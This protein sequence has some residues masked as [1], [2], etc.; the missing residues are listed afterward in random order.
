MFKK[1]DA[2][3]PF[4]DEPNREVGVREYARFH[5][6]SPA[7]ASKRLHTLGREGF[8]T[9]KKGRNCMLYKANDSDKYKDY[10]RAQTIQRLRASGLLEALEHKL[11]PLAVFLFGSAAKAENWKSSD[12]D[13]FALVRSKQAI[14]VHAY[15]KFLGTTIHLFLVT[16]NEVEQL[17]QKNP[18]LL[19]NII[20][21]IRLAGFWE[22][23]CV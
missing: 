22:A 6:I 16:P 4:V 18:H 1:K 10:K 12:I 19:N 15:E 21:G 14:G 23:F 9:R 17:R 20:N 13:I 7:T 5:Q 3:T 11:H 8:L 2:L